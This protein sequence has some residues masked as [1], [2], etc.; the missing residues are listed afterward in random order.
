MFYFDEIINEIKDFISSYY[1]ELIAIILFFSFGFM[2]GSYSNVNKE[3]YYEKYNKNNNMII[4][5]NEKLN[6]IM[7]LNDERLNLEKELNK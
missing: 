7:M 3:K 4:Q 6:E 1:K 2:L 5:I